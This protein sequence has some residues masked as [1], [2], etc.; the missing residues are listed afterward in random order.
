MS[1]KHSLV[2][3]EMVQRGIQLSEN[4][5]QNEYFNAAAKALNMTE[6][7]LTNYLWSSYNPSNIWIIIMAIGLVAAICL[8]F[9]HKKLLKE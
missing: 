5:T 8:W 3:E 6:R 4:L 1:D 9:Y 2:H 7:Q